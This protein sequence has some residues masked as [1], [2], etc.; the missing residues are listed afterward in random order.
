MFPVSGCLQQIPCSL[1]VVDCSRSHVTYKWVTAEDPVFPV[2]DCLQQIPCSLEVVDCS[3]SHVPCEW[4]AVLT[5]VLSSLFPTA[6]PCS[7]VIPSPVSSSDHRKSRHQRPKI[8]TLHDYMYW[9]WILI[10]NKVANAFKGF[11]IY[12]KRPT[13]LNGHLRIRDFTLTSCQ[14][15]SYLYINNPIIE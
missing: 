3:R 11:H 15:G 14:K 8:F 9:R 1:V 2:S 10:S 6:R 12:N 13:D 7:G 5:R 4:L